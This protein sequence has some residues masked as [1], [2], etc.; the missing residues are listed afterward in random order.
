MT[1]LLIYK[2]PRPFH[3]WLQD[4]HNDPSCLEKQYA[5][6]HSNIGYFMPISIPLVTRFTQFVLPRF[7]LC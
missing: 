3:K 2:N 4:L 1:I 7:I 6:Y 5:V